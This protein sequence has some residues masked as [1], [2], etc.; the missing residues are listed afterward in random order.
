MPPGAGCFWHTPAR[1]D[2]AL[3]REETD[4]TPHFLFVLPKRKRAAAG[5]KEKG[6]YW[7]TERGL[8]IRPSYQRLSP[9]P[10]CPLLLAPRL[11]FH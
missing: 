4:S 3:R 6:A 7:Q 11:P 10:V 2:F 8:T 1:G 9:K 5:P